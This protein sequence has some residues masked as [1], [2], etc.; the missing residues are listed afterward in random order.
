MRQ[1]HHTDAPSID[2]VSRHLAVDA[3]V[4]EHSSLDVV[5][6]TAVARIHI[7]IHPL[8]F[9]HAIHLVLSALDPIVRLLPLQH[10]LP[11]L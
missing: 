11:L 9:Y 1:I 7:H 4:V 6:R 5:D 8:R 2:R 10:L 3:A